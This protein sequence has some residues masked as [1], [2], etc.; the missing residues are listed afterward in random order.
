MC[1]FYG[2]NTAVAG[3]LAKQ[4]K[5]ARLTSFAAVDDKNQQLFQTE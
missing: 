1:C 4:K 3:I 5:Q 2:E